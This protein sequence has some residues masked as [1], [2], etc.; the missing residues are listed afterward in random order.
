[1]LLKNIVDY[2][3]ILNIDFMTK[4]EHVTRTKFVIKIMLK[5]E[6][7]NEPREMTKEA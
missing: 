5:L 3:R 4:I 7:L 2:I 6:L 1:M